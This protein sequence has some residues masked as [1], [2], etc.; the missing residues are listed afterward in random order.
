MQCDLDSLRRS[1]VSQ[2]GDSVVIFGACRGGLYHHRLFSHLNIPVKCFTD[3][4]ARKIGHQYL[5]HNVLAVEEAVSKYPAATFVL[6]LLNNVNVKKARD[7]LISFGVSDANIKYLTP[8]VIPLYISLLTHR[9]IDLEKYSQYK[10]DLMNHIGLSRNDKLSET[11]TCIITERCNLSC[12]N[13]TVFVPQNKNPR[14]FDAEAIIE[15]VKSYAKCFDFVYRVCLMGGEPFLHKNFAH[16]AAEIAK[17]DNILFIDIATNGTVVPPPGIMQ[18]CKENGLGVE[19]SDYGLTSRKMNELFDECESQ[20]VVFFRQSY[21]EKQWFTQE[22]LPKQG[23]DEATNNAQYLECT[24]HY[25]I[26]HIIDGKLYKC[27]F[28]AMADGLNHLDIDSV[29]YVDL[30]AEKI[31]ELRA[32]IKNLLS[33]TSALTACD[34]CSAFQGELVPAGIQTGFYPHSDR[35]KPAKEQKIPT[36]QIA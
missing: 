1:V 27:L 32:E 25:T 29:D 9:S 24:E 6:S 19:V 17:I 14:T 16:I 10:L 36:T 12:Q 31:S 3:N 11:L 7:Q 15:S 26:P 34:S 13:C 33:R 30:R 5:G 28:S 35:V 4:S 21:Q 8:D 22:I 2:A 20:G 18:V 23:R